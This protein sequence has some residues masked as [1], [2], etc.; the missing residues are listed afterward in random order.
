[1]YKKKHTHTHTHKKKNIGMGN[2]QKQLLNTLQPR[3]QQNNV[4]IVAWIV[5]KVRRVIVLVQYVNHVLKISMV[6]TVIK[7]IG[8][9]VTN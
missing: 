6:K 5:N 2:R 8:L 1:M 3:M 9:S 7:D 4:W